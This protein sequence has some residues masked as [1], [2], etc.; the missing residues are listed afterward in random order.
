MNHA[1]RRMAQLG[2]VVFLTVSGSG[3]FFAPK[4]TQF[5]VTPVG[6]PNGDNSLLLRI[7]EL[8]ERKSFDE[9]FPDDFW[10]NDEGAIGKDALVLR[11]ELVL[12]PGIPQTLKVELKEETMFVGLAADFRNRTGDAWKQVLPATSVRRKRIIVT[13]SDGMVQV[14]QQ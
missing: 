2:I 3:C 7:Y 9:A 8:K 12:L 10:R 1:R 5:S 14:M 4:G 6:R 11:H 13:V